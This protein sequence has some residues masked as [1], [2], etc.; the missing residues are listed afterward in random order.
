MTRCPSKHL[1]PNQEKWPF[2]AIICWKS[3]SLICNLW[4]TYLTYHILLNDEHFFILHDSKSFPKSRN[5]W[6]TLVYELNDPESKPESQ[7]A[8]ELCTEL[9]NTKHRESWFCHYHRWLKRQKEYW[10]SL[11]RVCLTSSY[12]CYL[13]KKK[14]LI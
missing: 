5:D 13:Y 1:F 9:P 3:P 11:G 10:I 14:S 4:L 7:S 12:S 6:Q 2:S 8:A